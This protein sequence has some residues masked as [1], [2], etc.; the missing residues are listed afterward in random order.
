MQNLASAQGY[1]GDEHGRR[2]QQ[3]VKK[4]DACFYDVKL[5]GDYLSTLYNDAPS[6]TCERQRQT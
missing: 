5:T 3:L 4:I 1:G 6:G 2:H